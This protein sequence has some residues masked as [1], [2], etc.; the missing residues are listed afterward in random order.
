MSNF[1]KLGNCK[2]CAAWNGPPDFTRAACK[3]HPPEYQADYR[4]AIYVITRAKDG[5]FD[6]ILK[7]ENSDE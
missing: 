3:R 1:P 7:E 2:N 4:E 6:F 5:C